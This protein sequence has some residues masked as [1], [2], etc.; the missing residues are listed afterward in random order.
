MKKNPYRFRIINFKESLA[1]VMVDKKQSSSSRLSLS[2]TDLLDQDRKVLSPEELLCI[3]V[4]TINRSHNAANASL[5]TKLRSLVAFA[6]NEQVF[7]LKCEISQ[8]NY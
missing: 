1:A 3:A 8:N 4:Q 7:E 2:T 6:L 5:D